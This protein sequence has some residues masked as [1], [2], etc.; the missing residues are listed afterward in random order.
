MVD[1][2]TRIPT[3]IAIPY[4]NPT[5]LTSSR[6][7]LLLIFSL[8]SALPSEFISQSAPVA[9]K[10]MIESDSDSDPDCDSEPRRFGVLLVCKKKREPLLQVPLGNQ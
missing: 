4:P 3:A 6:V 2:S 8:V 7:E 1:I 5:L 10:P 9:G